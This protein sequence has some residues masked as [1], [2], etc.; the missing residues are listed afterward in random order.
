[1]FHPL[2]MPRLIDER[3]DRLLAA[4]AAIDDPFEQA[5][6][7]MMHLPYLQPFDDASKRVSR[8]AVNI[9]I[10]SRTRRSEA[11]KRIAA[12]TRAVIEPK[13]R[14]Q[15]NEAA[16]AELTSLHEGNFARYR[17]RP[18]EFRAW[19]ESWNAGNGSKTS[20]ARSR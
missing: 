18:S 4:A 12:W 15:F 1:M 16:Q 2:E 9:L 10:R 17:V 5:F 19:W 14:K 13:D 8:L 7:V 6:F 20:A 11:T 3:F